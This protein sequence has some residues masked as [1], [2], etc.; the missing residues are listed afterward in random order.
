M[1]D[2]GERNVA[3]IMQMSPS[4]G[5]LL[6]QSYLLRYLHPPIR[7][8]SELDVSEFLFIKCESN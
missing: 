5:R 3:N 4:R 7:L 1:G 8:F 2:L 6:R